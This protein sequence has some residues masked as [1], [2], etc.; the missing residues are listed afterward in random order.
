MGM[1]R[2]YIDFSDAYFRMVSSNIKSGNYRL[3]GKGSG[4]AVYDL[5]NG[6][7]VKAAKNIR[8]IAQNFEEHK[9]ARIDHSN[10]FARV[11]DVSN[12]YRYLVMDKADHIKDISSV[13]DYFGVGSN[14]ELF[15]VGRLRDI[16]DKY[17]LLIW[18]FGRAVNWG[19][20]DGKPM[21]IDYG[22]T[23]LVRR[24]YY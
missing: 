16:S 5:D 12:D 15:Q 24:K 6:Q 11:Y 7:V 13:W 22:F 20:I 9:I 2:H 17:N 21:I 10:L 3:I 23:R 18:D 19:E 14:N 8:G 4:R 1:R